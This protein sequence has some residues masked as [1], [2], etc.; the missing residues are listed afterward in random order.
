ML[1]FNVV[2]S[3]I[4]RID[5]CVV[6]TVNNIKSIRLKL[7]CVCRHRLQCKDYNCGQQPGG[8]ADVGYSRTGEVRPQHMREK[9]VFV[10]VRL[11][12]FL[13]KAFLLTPCSTCRYRSIT[14]Q[15][16]RKADG[17]LVMYDVTAEQS[18]TAVRQWLTSV[19]VGTCC[20]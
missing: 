3:S 19:Q 12:R 17:V 11:H 2:T 13:L 15:F 20:V 9:S 8:A 18:F 10:F 5:L 14:K 1:L 7:C 16:F 4:T 6:G